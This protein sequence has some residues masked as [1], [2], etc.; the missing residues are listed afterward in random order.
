[1]VHHPTLI[2][3]RVYLAQRNEN[4][5]VICR[6]RSGW[7]VLGDHQFFTGYSLLLADPVVNHLTDLD[8]A[9]RSVFLSDMALLGEALHECTDTFRVNYEILGNGDAALHAHLF[10]RYLDEPEQ[11]RRGPVWSYPSEERTSVE[12]DASVHGDLQKSIASYVTRRLRPP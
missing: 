7:A 2:H 12:F 3:E 9:S 8:D 11:C 10:P 5:T 1:V 4:P 6:M